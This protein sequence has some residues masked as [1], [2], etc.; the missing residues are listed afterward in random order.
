[1]NSETSSEAYTNPLLLSALQNLDC[2][3]TH[4]RNKKPNLNSMSLMNKASLVFL[5]LWLLLSCTPAD[6]KPTMTNEQTAA[7]KEAP[8]DTLYIERKIGPDYY[9][10]VFIEQDRQSELY[11]YL[12]DFRFNEYDQRA[13]EADYAH[14]KKRHPESFKKHNLGDLEKQWLP[15]CRYKEQFY[16]Y[17]KCNA[18]KS[19]NRILTDSLIYGWTMDGPHVDFILKSVRKV[20]PVKYVLKTQSPFDLTQSDDIVIHIV[21][22]TTRMAVWEYNEAN[23]K[24]RYE[25]YVPSDYVHR[26]DIVVNHCKD[27]LHSEYQTEETDFESLLRKQ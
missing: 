15:L 20:S 12:V 8:N 27:R 14:L 22:T 11:Q 19:G 5:L 17:K 21:D 23:P 13:F 25:L 4:R 18:A 10:A 7:L 6:R 2:R 26:F 16:L 24:L 9:Y 3:H 1:M